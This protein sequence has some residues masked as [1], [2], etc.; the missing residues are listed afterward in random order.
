MEIFKIKIIQLIHGNKYPSL[1]II[2][3]V[4]PFSLS[5]FCF[6]LIFISGHVKSDSISFD[7]R[8]ELYSVNGHYGFH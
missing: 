4:I 7:L 1:L 5:V 6:Y 3:R 2:S 8:N